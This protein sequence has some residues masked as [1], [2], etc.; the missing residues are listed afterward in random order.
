MNGVLNKDVL[1]AG[2]ST[3]PTDA[4]EKNKRKTREDK[5]NQTK[6]GELSREERRE[7]KKEKIIITEIGV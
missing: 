3:A 4:L 5:K 7:E 2:V 1:C 6:G